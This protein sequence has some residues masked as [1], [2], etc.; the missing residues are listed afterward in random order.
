MPRVRPGVHADRAIMLAFVW[1]QAAQDTDA[2]HHI[3]MLAIQT[4]TYGAQEDLYT[5][6]MLL[7]LRTANVILLDVFKKRLAAVA[8]A[9][10][11]GEVLGSGG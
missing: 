4:A 1:S 8:L 10:A 2:A 9:V 3:A 7:R 5:M 6:E 11:L